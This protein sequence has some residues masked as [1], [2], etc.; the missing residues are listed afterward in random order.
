MRQ[1]QLDRMRYIYM[2]VLA[3]NHVACFI[4]LLYESIT[5]LNYV[6]KLD[7]EANKHTLVMLIFTIP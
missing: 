4:L 2:H 6:G 1:K 5:I 7:L 3:L